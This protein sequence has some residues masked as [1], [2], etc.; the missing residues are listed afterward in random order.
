MAKKPMLLSEATPRFTVLL[1]G[2]PKV[3]KTTLAATAQRHPDMADV[4][5]LDVDK[6][7]ASVVST[8]GISKI[9]IDTG[10]EMEE[11]ITSLTSDSK[12]FDGIRTVVVDSLTKWLTREKEAL[13]LAGFNRNRKGQ[14][15]RDELQIKDFGILTGRITRL[16]G[17]LIDDTRRHVILNAHKRVFYLNK[18]QTVVARRTFNANEALVNNIASM[19]D[20]IWV[21]QRDNGTIKMLTQPMLQFMSGTSGNRFPVKLGDTVELVGRRDENDVLVLEPDLAEIY[22][23]YLSTEYNKGVL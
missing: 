9:E 8:S 4:L 19:F 10:D 12:D 18:E 17:N 15:S 20:N 21:L 13:G 1:Y 23:L 3:G 16:M 22:D 2:E 7:L 14:S 5:F 11:V 6:R